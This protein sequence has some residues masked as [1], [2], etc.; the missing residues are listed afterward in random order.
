MD[1]SLDQIESPGYN[2]DS[3]LFWY[4]GER[5]CDMKS[6]V[7]SGV[8]EVKKLPTPPPGNSA[9]N[10]A[11]RDGASDHDESCRLWD[12]Y[13]RQKKYLSSRVRDSDST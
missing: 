5:S 6:G 11:P 12:M 4:R 13:L 2:Y 3:G 7:V 9:L 1:K 10:G 8:I